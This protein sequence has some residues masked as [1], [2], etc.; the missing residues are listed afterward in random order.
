LVKEVI[1]FVN[2]LVIQSLPEE[3]KIDSEMTV[4]TTGAHL[5]PVKIGEYWHWVV[6]GFEE[7]TFYD[8][9][10]VSVADYAE[11]KEDLIIS[12]EEGEEE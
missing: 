7:D 9:E 12:E 2:K 5:M 4:Y 8:G 1:A 3:V 11:N 6:T 10:Y